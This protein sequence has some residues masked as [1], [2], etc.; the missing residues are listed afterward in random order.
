[1]TLYI[2]LAFTSGLSLRIK[3][4]AYFT[5]SQLSETDN[6]CRDAS[7]VSSI[8]PFFESDAPE[9]GKCTRRLLRHAPPA[10]QAPC[11]AQ[12]MRV[13]TGTVPYLFST[14]AHSDCGMVDTAT[15]RLPNVWWN[16]HADGNQTLLLNLAAQVFS[17]VPTSASGERSFNRRSRVHTRIRKRLSDVK[18]DMTQA[19]LFN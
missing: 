3:G 10:T 14:S 13:V 9:C 1:M 8:K 17:S 6:S 18:A 12:V 2:R 19:I 16:I 15:F 5:K 11:V 7:R 4:A